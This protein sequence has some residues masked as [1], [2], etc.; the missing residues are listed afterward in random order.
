MQKPR[1]KLGEQK[2]AEIPFD[3]FQ[4][5]LPF[6]YC[7]VDFFGPFFYRKNRQYLADEI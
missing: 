7:G 6:T 3:R 1:G 5:E 4:E 2:M